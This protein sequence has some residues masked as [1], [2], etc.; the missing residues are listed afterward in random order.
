MILWEVHWK[1][2]EVHISLHREPYMGCIFELWNSSINK[3]NLYIYF[4]FGVGKVQMSSFTPIFASLEKKSA[5]I[6]IFEEVT[7]KYIK[8]IGKCTIGCTLNLKHHHTQVHFH[9]TIEFCIYT[10]MIP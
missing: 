4:L 2:L 6:S 10:V 7:E 8:L 5:L 1:M 9:S 3:K